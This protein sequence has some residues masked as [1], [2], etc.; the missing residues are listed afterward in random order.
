MSLRAQIVLLFALAAALPVLA[1]SLVVHEVFVE[2]AAADRAATDAALL[3]LHRRLH[4]ERVATTRRAVA[5]LCDGEYAIDAVT[6]DLARGPLGAA[7]EEDLDASLPRLARA[8]G[9]DALVVLLPTG[10]VLGAAVAP[11]SGR[12]GDGLLGAPSRF[13]RLSRREVALARDALDALEA[14]ERP[15]V[16]A[17]GARKALVGAC[18]AGSGAGRVLVVGGLGVERLA[19]SALQ[20]TERV[21]EGAGLVAVLTDAR[22]APALA[23]RLESDPGTPGDFRERDPDA[24]TPDEA[25][26]QTARLLVYGAPALALVLGALLGLVAARRATRP[27]DLLRAATT[28]VAAGDLAS[29]IGAARGPRELRATATAFDRMTRELAQT[30]RK[31]VRTERIAAWRDIARRIA[32]EIK[33]PLQPIRVSIE[34]MRKTYARKHPDFDEIFQESTLAIL[35]EVQRLERIVTEFSRFARLPRPRPEPLD[36]GEVLGH[37][38]SLHV[39]GDVPLEV[40]AAGGLPTI[41]ADREQLVQVFVNLA[42]NAA[43]AAR[44]HRGDAAR[45]R[46]VVAPVR[47]DADTPAA[48]PEPGVRVEVQDNGAGIPPGDERQRVFEPYY[49]TKAGGTGLGLAIAHRIVGEH[50]GTIEIGD[51]P[52]ELGG[53][54]VR[55]TLRASGPPPEADAS[56]SDGALRLPRRESQP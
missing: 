14:G 20:V 10:E 15:F 21:D 48:A 6:A 46:I 41:R 26:A 52:A 44:A 24:P 25:R 4:E 54:S 23:L 43:D 32:H 50:L 30:Q 34:T 27:L 16:A 3:A 39:T 12:D 35:D 11:P 42:Q 13:A 7:R 38:Q 49:T 47:V 17:L 53:A 18:A 1:V 36:V 19:G 55:V 22:G 8:L 9:L 40:E 33:N 37:V 51:A 5:R 45:V 31:L 28:R 56:A 29:T 2:G